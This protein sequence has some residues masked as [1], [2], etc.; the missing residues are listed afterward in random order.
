M[1]KRIS[2]L[3][4]TIGAVLL[5]SALLLFGYNE[6]ES[7]QA[8]QASQDVLGQMKN[9]EASAETGESTTD[10]SVLETD[11]QDE[12]ETTDSGDTMTTVEIN[13]YEYIGYLS[14]PSLDM[15]LPIVSQWDYTRLAIAPCRQ[16]GSVKG[17]DLVIAGHNYRSH[18]GPLSRIAVG[19]EVTF[20]DMDG[21]VYTYTVTTT[22][23]VAP[24]MVDAVEN[25]GHDL[26]LYSC[27]YGGQTRHVVFCDKTEE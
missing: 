18:F 24:E 21:N 11:V 6:W 2:L 8:G 12:N 25:S 13:G 14:I 15:E 16:F 3:C 26:V 9:I 1:H 27:T 22:S 17:N 4:I 19:A 10:P 5:I 20:T 7:I 23:V